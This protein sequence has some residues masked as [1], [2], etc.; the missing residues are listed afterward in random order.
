MNGRRTAVPSNPGM[1][2]ALLPKA[3]ARG[4]AEGLVREATAPGDPRKEVTL[5]AAAARTCVHMCM[6]G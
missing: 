3:K 6:S 4:K 1:K 2:D 5:T